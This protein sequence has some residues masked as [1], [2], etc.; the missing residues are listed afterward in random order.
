MTAK[1]RSPNWQLLLQAKP[2]LDKNLLI[3]KFK[4]GS[5]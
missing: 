2:P 5:D 1:H 4:M 3:L